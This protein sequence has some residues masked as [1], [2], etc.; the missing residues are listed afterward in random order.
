M[1]EKLQKQN[2][3][4]DEWSYNNYRK[5]FAVVSDPAIN[6]IGKISNFFASIKKEDYTGRLDQFRN[7]QANRYQ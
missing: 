5:V 4:L 7:Q 6:L 3:P 1:F 2:T